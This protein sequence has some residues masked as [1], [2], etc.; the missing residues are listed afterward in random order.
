M[1]GSLFYS[2][3][4]LNLIEC[5]PYLGFEPSLKFSLIGIVEYFF[6]KFHSR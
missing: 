5:I 3:I 4:D 2:F 1:L 6:Q